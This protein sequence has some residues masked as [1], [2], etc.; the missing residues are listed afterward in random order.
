MYVWGA[1]RKGRNPKIWK[2]MKPG[3]Y[4]LGYRKGNF[5]S[6]SRI[7]GKTHNPKLAEKLWG[8]GK[9]PDNRGLTWEY[10]Y[11]LEKIADFTIPSPFIVRGHS[12]PLTGEKRKQIEQIITDILKERDPDY[13]KSD[14][15][16]LE[17]AEQNINQGNYRVEDSWGVRR[18]RLFRKRWREIVLQRFKWKCAICGLGIKELLDAAHIRSWAEY[19]DYRLDPKNGIALC[20]LHHR[21][22]DLGLIKINQYGQ[23]E[24]S[25]ELRINSDDIITLYFIKF[26]GQKIISGS[27]ENR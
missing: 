16:L 5:I 7:V 9:N 15:E 24:C 25:D 11:F 8:V 23:I 21:A 17:E 6:L 13:N 18:I 1:T 19:P 22:F 4:V 2:E 26:C 10:I 12:G 3:D 27:E 14:Q 20:V